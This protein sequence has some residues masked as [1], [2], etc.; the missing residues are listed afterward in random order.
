MAKN[1]KSKKST[2][3]KN[4]RTLPIAPKK[5]SAG[6]KPADFPK[7]LGKPIDMKKGIDGGVDLDT[8]IRFANMFATFT[9]APIAICAIDGLKHVC[10]FSNPMHDLHQKC[11]LLGKKLMML[12]PNLR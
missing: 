3:Q 12:F 10:T 8:Q 7:R 11:E 1:R 9:Q 6:I 2:V 5:S 4:H